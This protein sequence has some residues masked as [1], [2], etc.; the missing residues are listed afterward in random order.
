M[1]SAPNQGAL[2]GD[3]SERVCI[4]RLRA[5][6]SRSVP[7]PESLGSNSKK[8]IKHTVLGVDK[9]FVTAGLAGGRVGNKGG[10]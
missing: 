4:Q 8:L 9:D 7:E 5:S 2:D 6:D 10:M 1:L 3:V